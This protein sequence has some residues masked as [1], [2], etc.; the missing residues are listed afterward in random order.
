[1]ALTVSDLVGFVAGVCTTASFLPQVVKI[2]H[3]RSTRDISLGMYCLLATGTILWLVH[4]AQI[5]SLPVMAANA[6]TLALVL[7]VLFLKVRYK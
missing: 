6:V 1:M 7:A 4:G 2:W 5:E 3:T